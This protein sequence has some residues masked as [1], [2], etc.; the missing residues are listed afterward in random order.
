MARTRPDATGRRPNQ[1]PGDVGLASPDIETCRVCT[2][3]DRDAAVPA[4]TVLRA[5]DR[6]EGPAC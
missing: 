6:T 1:G 3:V 5:T 2:D 4:Q